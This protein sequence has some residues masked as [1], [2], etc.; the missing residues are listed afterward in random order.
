M[1]R[2]GKYVKFHQHEVLSVI[3]KSIGR[4]LVVLLLTI[5]FLIGTVTPAVMAQGLTMTQPMLSQV[6]GLE[7]SANWFNK[8]KQKAKA[9]QSDL[10][11]DRF[12]LQL[13]HASDIESGLQALEPTFRTS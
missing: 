2:G 6:P 10:G 13:L 7:L 3:L 8:K 9:K 5:T 11:S 4:W 12:T 1:F